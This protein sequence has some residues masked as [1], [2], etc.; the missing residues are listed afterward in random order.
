M[1]ADFLAVDPQWVI[2]FDGGPEAGADGKCFGEQPH[3]R[4]NIIHG[5]CGKTRC[6]KMSLEN[7]LK[8]CSI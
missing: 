7:E 6:L 3:W 1:W 5:V 4:N 8:S 2:K